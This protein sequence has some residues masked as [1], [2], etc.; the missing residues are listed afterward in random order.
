M[1]RVGNVG[2]GSRPAPL[3]SNSNRSA[4]SLSRGIPAAGPE[5][6]LDPPFT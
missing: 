6:R 1:Q 2:A 4:T 5:N 3:L